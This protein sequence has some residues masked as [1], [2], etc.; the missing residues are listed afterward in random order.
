MGRL[1]SEGQV[2]LATE[3]AFLSGDWREQLLLISEAWPEDPDE[4]DIDGFG[5]WVL[6]DAPAGL[7][8]SDAGGRE[9]WT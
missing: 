2:R 7:V 9:W 8:W 6:T 4:D 3:G 5:L 1:L